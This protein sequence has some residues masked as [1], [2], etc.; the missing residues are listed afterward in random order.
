M[1]KSKESGRIHSLLVKRYAFPFLALVVP[2]L[3]KAVPE[4]LMGPY[5]V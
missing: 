5:A 4:V 2:L 1:F 3:L